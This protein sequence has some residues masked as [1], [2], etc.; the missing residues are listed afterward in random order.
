MK[1]SFTNIRNYFSISPILRG[2]FHLKGGDVAEIGMVTENPSFAFWVYQIGTIFMLPNIFKENTYLP[3]Y[4]KRSWKKYPKQPIQSAKPKR[5]CL[6]HSKKHPLL[7]FKVQ[8][9]PKGVQGHER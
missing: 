2:E 8:A 5:L 4:N 7:I 1:P 9:G 3:L 6:P